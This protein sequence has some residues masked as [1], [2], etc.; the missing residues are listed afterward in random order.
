M[1]FKFASNLSFMFTECPSILGRYKLAKEAGFTAV[2]SGFPLGC[3]I[4]EIVEAKTSANVNQILI[5][6][7]TGDTAKGE[8]GFAAVPGKE[9]EFKKSIEVT[10]EYAKALNC[11]KIHVMSGKVESPNASNDSVYRSNLRY[12]VERFESEGIVGLIEPINSITVPNYYMNSF[13]KGLAVVKDIDSPNLKL[14]LDV[15]HLQHS[16]GNITHT[17]RNN[18][19]YIGHIQVAQVPDRYEPDTS[20]EINYEYVFS[21]LEKVGYKD[22]IGLEYKPKTSTGEGLRWIKKMGFSL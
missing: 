7:F 1:S 6:V 21:L 5:N 15:F 3:S 4:Q 17:I 13:E 18:L 19:S 10:I 11:K 22:Y 16:H 20:G 2:E 14:M 12:A 8:L 9:T